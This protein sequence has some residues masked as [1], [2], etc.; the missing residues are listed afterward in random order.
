MDGA[1]LT[2]LYLSTLARPTLERT[3]A[4]AVESEEFCGS[5][6]GVMQTNQPPLRAALRCLFEAWPAALTFEALWEQVRA[7]LPSLVN[8][9]GRLEL[10]DALLQCYLAR[11]VNLHLRPPTL[12]AEP[13]A[14]PRASAL[15][16][17]QAA[18]NLPVCN[19]YHRAVTLNPFDQMVLRQLDGTRG[20]PAVVE[21]MAALVASG[22][23]KV[24]KDGAAVHDHA[25]LQNALEQSLG[26]SLD[27]IAQNAL[28]EAS[29]GP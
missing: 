25:L 17:F 24:H 20:R 6:G 19:L 2:A 1:A 18:T 21:A 15:A 9:D 29:D 27:R 16:R 3:E 12:A 8:D 14:R 23:L 26:A 7:R 11:M 4:A 10:A 5:D 28:L 22:V 13:G